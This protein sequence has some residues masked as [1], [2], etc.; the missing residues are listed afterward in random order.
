MSS[1]NIYIKASKLQF[2]FLIATLAFIV[3][4]STY[5]DCI[6][7]GKVF[8]VND[9]SY[10]PSAWST[11]TMCEVALP[12]TITSPARWANWVTARTSPDT[13][14]TQTHAQGGESEC[15]TVHHVT[16]FVW[17]IVLCS[18]AIVSFE[19]PRLSL[20]SLWESTFFHILNHLLCVC[21]CM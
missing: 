7:C 3:C 6:D 19:H 15:E 14:I 5:L 17:H 16:S 12:C 21:V 11:G 13:S 2:W 10:L 4:G 18:L 9:I 1:N 8:W 20:F